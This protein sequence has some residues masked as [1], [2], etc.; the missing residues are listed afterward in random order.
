[1][2]ASPASRLPVKTRACK[3]TRLEAPGCDEHVGAQRGSPGPPPR[4][5]L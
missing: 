3:G 4:L 1:V 2:G 5:T